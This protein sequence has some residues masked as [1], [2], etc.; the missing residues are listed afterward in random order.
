MRLASGKVI[1]GARTS[2]GV[3]TTEKARSKVVSEDTAGNMI[4][5]I[6]IRDWRTVLTY[7]SLLYYAT[8]NKPRLPDLDEKTTRAAASPEKG[9]SSVTRHLLFS[10]PASIHIGEERNR[11][12]VPRRLIQ[13]PSQFF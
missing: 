7:L 13:I 5:Q 11:G 8:G 10:I 3:A 2:T 1:W 9:L 4:D 12:F 6:R